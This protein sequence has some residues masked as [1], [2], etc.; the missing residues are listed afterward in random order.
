MTRRL[1]KF[2]SLSKLPGVDRLHR[3][4]AID[5]LH[6]DDRGA[7][8]VITTLL[9]SLAL[10]P[11]SALVVDVGTLYV[12]REELQSGADSAAVRVAQIC[13]AGGC[14][15]PAE[16]AAVVAA[17]DAY[18]DSNAKDQH[19][20][21]TEIC[22]SWDNLPACSTPP[23]NS[24]GNCFAEIPDEE[25]AAKIG[26]ALGYLGNVRTETLRAFTEDEYRKIVSEL[27]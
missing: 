15:T 4:N 20:A 24:L 8:M 7:A 14:D 23:T 17:A 3:A 27:P 16:L 6:E 26:L 21:V 18:A 22:G 11:M 10:V 12:E 25:T 19:A 2:G 5:R 9:L 13:M 1:L